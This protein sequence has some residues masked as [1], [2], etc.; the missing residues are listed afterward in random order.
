MQEGNA[1]F[2]TITKHWNI[3]E[4]IMWKYWQRPSRVGGLVDVG[5]G[6][7]SRSNSWHNEF[8]PGMNFPFHKGWQSHCIIG[9]VQCNTFGFQLFSQICYIWD[10]SRQLLLSIPGKWPPF[11]VSIMNA[12][13]KER[14]I[15]SHI[16]QFIQIIH[17]IHIVHIVWVRSLSALF[18][19]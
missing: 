6:S 4:H 11:A 10:H 7:F 8:P 19:N 14:N 13:L 15:S 3:W 9:P 12:Q 16:I 5:L 1:W 2:I 17:I 18:S